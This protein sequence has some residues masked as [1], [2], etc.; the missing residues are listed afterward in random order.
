MGEKTMKK[1]LYLLFLCLTVTPCLA[2]EDL[3]EEKTFSSSKIKG[4]KFK[5]DG[6]SIDIKPSNEE[7]SKIRFKKNNN[8]G[9]VK[10]FLD[11]EELNIESTNSPNGGFI[12]DYEVFV[13]KETPVSITT[14]SSKIT[15]EEMGD[16]DV[17]AGTLK[18]KAKNLSGNN[19]FQFASGEAEIDYNDIPNHSMSSHINSASGKITFFFPS[20]ASVKI[21]SVR[22][23]L[24]ESDFSSS[25][26]ALFPIVFNS[27]SGKLIIKKK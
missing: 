14:G 23:N 19:N 16:L 15:V 5:I 4:L 13:E 24:V 17:M 10:I 12:V 1:H 2:M 20:N 11:N 7:N 25:L 18:L 21:N 9:D 3:F 6:G 22:P 27:V 8:K 26:K